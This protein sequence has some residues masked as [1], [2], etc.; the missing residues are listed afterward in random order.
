MTVVMTVVI[1]VPRDTRNRSD[2]LESR[3]W[4]EN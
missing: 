3:D 1:N 4:L 2:C